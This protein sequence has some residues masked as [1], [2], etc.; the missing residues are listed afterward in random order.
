MT[1][2]ILFDL[3]GTIAD[4][5]HRLHHILKQPKDWKSFHAGCKSDAPIECIVKLIKHLTTWKIHA[6][7]DIW[8][9]TGRSSSTRKDTEA[10][11]SEHDILYDK[12]IMR[13]SSDHTDD[14]ILKVRWLEDGTIPKDQVL[15]VFEDRSRVV[16]AWRAAG[17]P[18]FQ[19]AEGDF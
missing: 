9:V 3:D 2:I 11:L 4:L 6:G 5:Q 8:I 18:C 17:I 16:K 12:L 7:P 14:D 1:D 13:P 10:W 19:V 15:C